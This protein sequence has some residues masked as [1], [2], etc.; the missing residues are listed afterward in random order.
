MRLALVGLGQAAHEI[1]LPAFRR[2]PELELVAAAEPDD[3]LREARA[4][5][6]GLPRVYKDLR[7]LLER[8]RPELVS[9]CTPPDTHADLTVEALAAGA[10]VLCEKPFVLSLAEADRVLA[11]SASAGRVV[12]INNQYPWMPIFA[13]ARERIHQ[14]GFGALLFLQA[15]QLMYQP[16]RGEGGWRGRLR[17]RTLY[18]FGNHVI[19]L[20][21]EFFETYPTRVTAHTPHPLPEEPADL[22]HLLT[23]DFSAGRS[24]HLLLNRLSRGQK[25]YLDMR[26]D[27]EASTLRLSLGGLARFRVGIATPSRRPYASLEWAG[28][29]RCWEETGDRRWLLARNSITPFVDAMV[30][31]VR[32]LLQ[33]LESGRPPSRTAEQA[34]RILEIVFSAY[35]SAERGAP[36][37][38]SPPDSAL[39]SFCVRKL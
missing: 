6:W 38:L 33:A 37:S 7:R 23:M 8:E 4:R 24:A 39:A 19:D 31:R 15:W 10:H 29:G 12:A 30:L 26:L 14:P 17:E 18:E 11:A 32:D 28:G 9:I 2:M 20:I 5:Q 16:S 36:V 27:G 25:R 1:Q 34:R 35:L 21:C 3:G 22:I 13:A